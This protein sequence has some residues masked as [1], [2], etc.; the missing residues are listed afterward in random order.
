MYHM[1][2]KPMDSRVNPFKVPDGYFDTLTEQVMSAIPKNEVVM[3]TPAT[4][5]R[6]GWEA[7]RAYAAAAAVV[8]ALFGAGIYFQNNTKESTQSQETSAQVATT[9]ADHEIDA[10]A[11]YIMADNYELYAYLSGE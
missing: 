4:P 9:T 8:G 10:M 11:D 5:K 2:E 7:W 1:K 6:K 3:M